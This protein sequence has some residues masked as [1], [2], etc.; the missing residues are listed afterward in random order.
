[1]LL[2]KPLVLDSLLRQV[3]LQLQDRSPHNHRLPLIN[4][5][6]HHSLPMQPREQT[7][8]F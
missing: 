4:Q 8:G 2:V 6:V 1:V 7:V 5:S 3:K